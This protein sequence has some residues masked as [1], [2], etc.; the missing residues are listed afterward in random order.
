M[1]VV[2]LLRLSRAIHF[3]FCYGTTMYEHGASFNITDRTCSGLPS[4][5]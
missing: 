5:P 4:S 2:V 1:N 3:S